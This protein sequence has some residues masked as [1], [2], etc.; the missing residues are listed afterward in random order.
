MNISLDGG[1]LTWIGALEQLEVSLVVDDNR[2]IHSLLTAD[3]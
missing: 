1:K 3:A 2:W